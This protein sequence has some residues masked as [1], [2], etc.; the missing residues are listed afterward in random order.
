MP[1]VQRF[2]RYQID[3]F[4]AENS[5]VRQEAA[6]EAGMGSLESPFDKLSSHVYIVGVV[7][8]CRKP[9]AG[10]KRRHSRF[11]AF[12]YGSPCKAQKPQ[13]VWSSAEV[14]KH[15]ESFETT[16]TSPIF[17]RRIRRAFKGGAKF[18]FEFPA[19]TIST[20]RS[21]MVDNLR[22]RRDN[23]IIAIRYFIKKNWN[24]KKKSPSK[25]FELSSSHAKRVPKTSF[26][27]N[28]LTKYCASS[29][30][31]RCIISSDS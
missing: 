13:H 24:S 8:K 28:F 2:G 5:A 25:G 12:A 6:T 9:G 11:F 15:A 21:A 1:R 10:I 18:E 20:G 22:F 7:C 16:P 3:W 26:F 23:A 30:N 17:P 31:V 19:K 14:K 4:C 27:T 29:I